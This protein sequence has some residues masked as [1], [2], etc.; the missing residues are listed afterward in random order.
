MQRSV[1]IGLL[2]LLLPLV[3]SVCGKK[4]DPLPPLTL[5]PKPIEQFELVQR[6]GLLILDWRLPTAYT[7]GSPLPGY[8]GLEFW[9]LKEEKDPESEFPVLSPEKLRESGEIIL[10]LSS[11]EFSR[12]QPDPEGSPLRFHYEH[13]LEQAELGKVR[14]TFALVVKD[15]KRRHSSFSQLRSLEPLVVSL[16]PGG[17]EAKVSV[18]SIEVS[19]TAP[20]GNLDKSEP[21][22]VK[23]YNLYR[24]DLDGEPMLINPSLILE[25]K[26]EDTNFAFG[27]TYRYLI[28]AAA[29]DYPPYIESADSQVLEVV[30]K[31]TFPPAVPKDLVAIA[32]EAFVSLSWDLGR[33]A[34]LS[35]YRVWRRRV[36]EEEFQCLTSEGVSESAYTDHSVMSDQ[37]YEYAVTAVDRVGNESEP[38]KPITI[39]VRGPG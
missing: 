30:A 29:N 24:A 11:E 5:V 38:S 27:E 37:E 8:S 26:F 25:T 28:R 9:M 18:K 15:K 12:Y 39:F 1:Q 20:A 19:W 23:G 10:E 32:G 4:G 6:G 14:V 16:P 33:D 13:T 17:L 36:G 35:V 22:A 21:A 34:D 31:D 2:V 7:D 3:F